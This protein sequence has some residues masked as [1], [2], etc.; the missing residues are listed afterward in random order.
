MP[1]ITEEAVK[2]HLQF[3][4]NI[5]ENNGGQLLSTKWISTTEK[6][7]FLYSNGKEIYISHKHLREKG[8]PKNF[9]SY[10]YQSTKHL[11]SSEDYLNEMRTIAKNNGG[12]LLSN[13][14]LGRKEKYR[15][16]DLNSMEFECP[17]LTL[18]MGVWVPERGL[19]SEPICIQA[20]E[21]IFGYQFKKTKKILTAKILNRTNPLELDGY[22]KELNIAFEFQG[23]R[24]HWDEKYPSYLETKERDDLKKLFC[25]QL[26]IVLVEIPPFKKN[27]TKWNSSEVLE[28]ILE[29]IYKAYSEYNMDMPKLNTNG[30]EINLGKISNND[31]MLKELRIVAQSNNG[32]LISTK[33]K[34]NEE[35]YIFEL[36]DGRTFERKASIIKICGWPKDLEMLFK[37]NE[38]YLQE[39]KD[40]A[41]ANGGKLLSTE[42]L[43]V[44]EK[45]L[46]ELSNGKTFKQTADTIRHY[47]WPKNLRQ[48]LTKGEDYLEELRQIAK[49]NGCKLLDSE[50]KGAIKKYCFEL[51]DGRIFER[52]ANSI[53]SNG[54]PKNIEILFKKD[55]DYLQKL[56]DVAEKNGGKLLSSEWKG[57]NKKY[58]FENHD[59]KIFEKY[60]C[61]ITSKGWPKKYN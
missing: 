3:L 11:K 26:G 45:Y 1:K 5:A 16:I 56:R 9:D 55:E 20:I 23:F 31:E 6:Y 10:L 49:I 22:C 18:M 30:F 15:F 17:Y 19:V 54:W 33:W 12:E 38:D 21:H 34:G 7:L 37:T 41:E 48:L 14:W 25:K 35:K 50:W 61:D 4:K 24:S 46:F 60:A 59:G 40:I 29:S 32:K 28:H 58:F 52:S 13:E 47:G 39:L 51:Q 2:N 44:K 57:V 42:Y 43:G 53:T 36:E 27:S 8:W